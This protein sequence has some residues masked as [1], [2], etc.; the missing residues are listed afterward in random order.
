MSFTDSSTY[1]ALL[2]ASR[3]VLGG[4]FVVAAIPKIADAEGFATAVEA[5]EM[6][7]MAAV[8]ILAII[9]PWT[10][11]ICGLFLISGVYVRPGAAIL[12]LLLVLFVVAISTAVLRGLNI[13]CGC[14]G[15]TGGTTVGWGKVL[16]D[17]GL[18]LPAW[19]LF[20][21]GGADTGPGGPDG[22]APG[23]RPV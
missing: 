10:E 18:M 11:L 23:A 12:G 20:R 16:E 3:V 8:N 15:E 6:V 21:S 13:N 9:I 17:I 1:R 5:Y 19:L 22:P 14:F 2:L 4:V 7:P